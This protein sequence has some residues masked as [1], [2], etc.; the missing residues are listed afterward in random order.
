M[1]EA[2]KR[3]SNTKIGIRF[4]IGIS[5]AVIASI[6]IMALE[7]FALPADLMR[8]LFVADVMLSLLFLAEYLYRLATAEN[9]RGYMTSF[10]GIMI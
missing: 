3:S 1:K 7:T 6:A 8:A 2:V 4:E 9:R 5:F 10:F